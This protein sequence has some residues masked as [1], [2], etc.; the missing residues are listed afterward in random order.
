MKFNNE[1]FLFTGIGSIY[2]TKNHKKLIYTDLIGRGGLVLL[3]SNS[4]IKISL[5]PKGDWEFKEDDKN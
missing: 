2:I 1:D 4:P 5:N 3:T